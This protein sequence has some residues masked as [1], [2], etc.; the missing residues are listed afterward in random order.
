MVGTPVYMYSMFHM[1]ELHILPT[2]YIYAGAQLE[3]SAPGGVITVA[4]IHRN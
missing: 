2:Q 1:E 3:F 4:A